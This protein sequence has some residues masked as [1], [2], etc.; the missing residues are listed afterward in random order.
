MWTL[1][2]LAA[3]AQYVPAVNPPKYDKVQHWGGAF[4]HLDV[5]VSLGTTG[6]GV[7]ALTPIGENW[8][9][10]GGVTYLPW[11]SKTMTTDVYV[12]K[13]QSHFNDVSELMQ[14]WKGYRMLKQ[15]KMSGM[16]SMF[17]AKILVDYFPLD[18]NKKFRVSAGLFWG[19]ARIANITPDSRYTSTLTTIAAYNQL[20]D[21]A[22]PGDPIRSWGYAGLY[23]GQ[24]AQDCHDEV[25]D[26]DHVEGDTYLMMPDDNGDLSIELR[27]NSFK[28]YL[29]V[30]Y[31]LG[32]LKKNENL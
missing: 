9:L 29:G 14:Q 18:D 25:H 6:I 22:D 17:N 32:F 2:V 31:E 13:D 27:T 30:G 20:Y 23:M 7:E 10:R 11:F 26:V 24:Y 28:P 3:H 21:S 8:R 12:G 5:M 4:Q 1:G 16:L 15:V 19:P